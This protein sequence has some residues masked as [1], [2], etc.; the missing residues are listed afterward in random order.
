MFDNTVE[1]ILA[2]N[3]NT[4]V[5]EKRLMTYMAMDVHRNGYDDDL[6]D[7]TV[8]KYADD[9]EFM[10]FYDSIEDI[11]NEAEYLLDTRFEYAS[12]DFVRAVA[13]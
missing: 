5:P 11:R 1:K 4:S 7:R 8:E 10:E 13:D 6:V 12:T 2:L 3:E 9:E